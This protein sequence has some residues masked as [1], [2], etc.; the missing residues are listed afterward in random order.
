MIMLLMLLGLF[1]IIGVSFFSGL[2]YTCQMDNIP[3]TVSSVNN[4]WDCLDNGGEWLNQRN[5]FDN[6][7]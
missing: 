4:Y 2:F 7:F 3:A 1:A 5:N 6:V